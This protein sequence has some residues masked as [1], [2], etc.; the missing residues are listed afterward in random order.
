MRPVEEWGD[1]QAC[2]HP[3]PEYRKSAR[4]L[5]QSQYLF[6]ARSWFIK[7]FYPSEVELRT[8]GYE[9][10]ILPS[11]ISKPLLP[12]RLIRIQEAV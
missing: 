7:T 9:N 4:E 2:L 5:L 1:L 11:A 10:F 6:G 3:H 8:Q 12:Q